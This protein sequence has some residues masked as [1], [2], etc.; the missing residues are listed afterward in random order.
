M[1]LEQVPVHTMFH[2]A[3]GPL[4]MSI[5]YRLRKPWPSVS[6]NV[7]LKAFRR[8]TV[9]STRP[10]ITRQISSQS[11]VA[12][13][14][15]RSYTSRTTSESLLESALHLAS[16]AIGYLNEISERRWER[17]LILDICSISGT[18]FHLRRILQDPTTKRDWMGI[19]NILCA[20]P[21][22]IQ[23][24]AA[25]MDH[26]VLTYPSSFMLKSLDSLGMSSKDQKELAEI[27]ASV[28]SLKGLLIFALRNDPM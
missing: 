20:V 25:D 9:K 18:L 16:Q 10:S 23:K 21:G 8:D 2:H 11:K 1:V 19:T 15:S 5:K 28:E 13:S 7:R 12:K 27:K 26:I 17:L 3:E 22:P 4:L 24:F 6:S 14:S